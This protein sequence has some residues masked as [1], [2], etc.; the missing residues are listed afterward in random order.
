MF[1]YIS[2]IQ[3]VKSKKNKKRKLKK[4]FSKWYIYKCP[5]LENPRRLLFSLFW[6]SRLLA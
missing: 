2:N 6:K 5:I 1:F 3:I 4:N